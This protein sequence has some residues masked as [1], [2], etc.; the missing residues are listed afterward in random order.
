MYQEGFWPLYYFRRD[1]HP[2]ISRA[3]LAVIFVQNFVSNA[4]FIVAKRLHTIIRIW[5]PRN[6]FTQSRVLVRYGQQTKL[7][8]M[9]IVN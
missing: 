7:E 9:Y 5:K 1:T 3:V 8:I 4:V 2:G 6:W